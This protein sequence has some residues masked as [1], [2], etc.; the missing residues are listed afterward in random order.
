M[1]RAEVMQVLRDKAVE[2]LAVEADAVQEDRSFVA[3]LGV[4]SLAFCE[5]AMDVE[6]ALGIE[7][8]EE[9]LTDLPTIGA[10]LDVV[11]GKLGTAL[12]SD[13]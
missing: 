10:F 12:N 6:D 1:E 8:P 11:M 4:D 7:L 2:R 13:G 3:D 5:Y 9:E